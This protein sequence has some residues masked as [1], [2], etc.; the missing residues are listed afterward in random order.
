M[1]RPHFRP[2]YARYGY[3]WAFGALAHRTGAVFVQTVATRDTV[4]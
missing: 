1:Y 2:D 4:A 3:R